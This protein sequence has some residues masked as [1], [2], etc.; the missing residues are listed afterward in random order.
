LA[1]SH[2]LK[3]L[4]IDETLAIPTLKDKD[5]NTI[6]IPVSSEKTYDVIK[7]L[8]SELFS[9][10]AKL[11]SNEL[12]QTEANLISRMLHCIRYSTTSAKTMK[13]YK[14][15]F[16]A[17]YNSDSEILTQYYQYFRQKIITLYIQLKEIK[18][19]DLSD[20]KMAQLHSLT[21]KIKAD[22]KTFNQTVIEKLSKK[23]ISE[24]V[25]NTL[26][27]AQRGFSQSGRQMIVSFKDFHLSEE[28]FSTFNEF[29]NLLI[30]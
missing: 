5:G 16:E 19:D 29:E 3:C 2:N 27:T 25:V 22:D 26:L 11:Q 13:D 28:E 10:A 8:Q 7:N 14:H 20:S 17:L 6:L 23:E 1:L 4:Y 30:D 12:N 24:N 15:E 21:E 18:T 9:F